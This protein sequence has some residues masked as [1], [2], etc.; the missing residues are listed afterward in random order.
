[1][2]REKREIDDSRRWEK[3]SIDFDAHKFE[4]LITLL[5]ETKVN[6]GNYFF[7]NRVTRWFGHA[8]RIVDIIAAKKLGIISVMPS[9]IASDVS[10]D[11]LFENF[12]SKEIPFHRVDPLTCFSL[13]QLNGIYEIDVDFIRLEG[14]F[15][16][17]RDFHNL[18]VDKWEESKRGPIFSLDENNLVNLVRFENQNNIGPDEWHVTFHN[19]S[20]PHYAFERNVSFESY[21][22]AIEEI[23]S[24]GGWVI[25]LG[26]YDPQSITYSNPKF[27]NYAQSPLSSDRL[28]LQLL[29]TCKFHLG[30]SSGVSEIP[31]MFGKQVLWTNVPGSHNHFKK[32][33]GLMLPMYPRRIKK[34]NALCVKNHL[35]CD[36]LFLPPTILE[37]EISLKSCEWV[38]NSP[39]EILDAVR[40]ILASSTME[41]NYQTLLRQRLEEHGLTHLTRTC[42][43]SQMLRT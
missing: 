10:N 29:A 28:D 40:E 16:N 43:S 39:D 15:Y 18:I 3:P 26:K 21:I 25:R 8:D 42:N 23:I 38:K 1:M 6:L 12:I 20:S 14:T 2:L 33:H 13:S 24:R 37:R 32:T 11:W 4:S 30:S 27:I 35:D 7:S 36:P 9:V 19:R 22:P 41:S 31:R 17:S 34:T 5:T